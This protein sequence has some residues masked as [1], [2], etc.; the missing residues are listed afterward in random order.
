VKRPQ[1]VHAGVTKAASSEV[2]APSTAGK[3]KVVGTT[4]KAAKVE[5]TGASATKGQ[6]AT[7][8]TGKS[9]GKQLRALA[10]PLA[11]KRSRDI[12]LASVE[13]SSR[14]I[15]KAEKFSKGGVAVKS[16]KPLAKRFC[17]SDKCT[18]GSGSSSSSAPVQRP[19]KR[20]KAERVVK[21][22][23][24][25]KVKAEQVCAGA[26]E[27]AL[28]EDQAALDALLDAEHDSMLLDIL[29]SVDSST[30]PETSDSIEE[31]TSEAIVQAVK[32]EPEVDRALSSVVAS[33][34]NAG[35]LSAQCGAMLASMLPFSL[36]LPSHERFAIQHR[37]VAMA[38][39][40]LLTAKSRMETAVAAADAKLNDLKATLAGLQNTA[41]EA[42]AE[43]AS[44]SASWRASLDDATSSASASGETLAER[45]SAQADAD[46]EM[47]LLQEDIAAL[48][49]AF[50][51]HFQ[52]PMKAGRGPHFH[53][54]ELF[55]VKMEIEEAMRE[56]LPEIC[57]KTKN[58]RSDS[59]ELILEQ[60]EMA[61]AV[62]ISVL[63]DSV[64]AVNGAAAERAAAVRIAEEDY[65]IKKE[66]QDK[67]A[68][69][70]Q[71]AMKAQSGGEE[72][73]M[74]GYKANQKV[75]E[76][77]SQLAAAT[78]M[79]EF[80]KVKLTNFE[81]GPLVHFM[82]HKTRGS[83]SDESSQCS[84][85]ITY[86][87]VFQDAPDM[88]LPTS[89]QSTETLGKTSASVTLSADTVV[90]LGA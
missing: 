52:K 19:L 14:V 71:A 11:L 6:L 24:A 33:V 48:E 55:L 8:K 22:E 40:T 20:V 79:L 50:Q 78:G 46:A 82:T 43:F 32:K 68:V 56:A 80:A 90:A 57:K 2:A 88:S 64:A 17:S 26:E 44:W 7:T 47:T 87:P 60:L 10:R 5:V 36:A 83:M 81:A 38:E 16:E 59:E 85:T 1:F 58:N 73:L 76:I 75:S 25:T 37:V 42:D 54:L 35:H 45:R 51:T 18:E 3:S 30:Q 31:C 63:T 74:K 9:L 21:T 67:S 34:A 84:A 23:R 39:E 89:E 49:K 29:D 65:S 12:L 66:V 13:D 69:D 72:A 15:C 4:V 28:D 27:A 61:I 62:R 41:K 86:C 70:F 77:R 53:E